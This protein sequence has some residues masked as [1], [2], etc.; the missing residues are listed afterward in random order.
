M[1]SIEHDLQGALNRI[2]STLVVELNIVLLFARAEP[3]Q[4]QVSDE[5]LETLQQMQVIRS[6]NAAQVFEFLLTGA[7]IC[8]A[9]ESFSEAV[10]LLL[11]KIDEFKRVRSAHK[12]IHNFSQEVE[13]ALKAGLPEKKQLELIREVIDQFRSHRREAYEAIA[14]V[15]AEKFAGNR[16]F[17]LF[18]YSACVLAALDGLSDATKKSSTVTVLEC[19]NKSLYGFDDRLIYS[20]GIEYARQ[21][22]NRRF[23]TVRLATDI[24]VAAVLDA[25]PQ[26]IVL[27]GADALEPSG[28]ISC[29]VGARVVAHA[30]AAVEQAETFVLAEGGKVHANIDWTGNAPTTG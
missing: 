23:A 4:M 7:E 6:P 24:S 17:V 21:V 15:A 22:K 16:K 26:S 27:L 28:D 1:E 5:L 14:K 19:R 3:T 10:S 25:D 18:G 29:T 30:A 12:Q 2:S 9:R 11:S 13:D 8:L 20:D